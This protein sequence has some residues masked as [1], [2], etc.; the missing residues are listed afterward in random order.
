[1]SPKHV[2]SKAEYV[3]LILF[4]RAEVTQHVL[5]R[6]L[7]HIHVTT[8]F[9]FTKLKLIAVTNVAPAAVGTYDCHAG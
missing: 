3:L 5:L 4:V 7:D 2:L 6:G 9:K 8:L 1:M